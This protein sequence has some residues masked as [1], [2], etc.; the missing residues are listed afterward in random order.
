MT[1]AGGVPYEDPQKPDVRLG[2]VVVSIQTKDHSG[3]VQFEYGRQYRSE[4]LDGFKDT[5]HTRAPEGLL[6][7]CA[8][9]IISPF[10]RQH[11]DE[12]DG[13]H[14][15]VRELLERCPTDSYHWQRPI[16]AH[17]AIPSREDTSPKLHGGLIA[18]SS[19][20]VQDAGF[21]DAKVKQFQDRGDILAFEMEGY[22]V[23]SLTPCLHIRGICDYADKSKNQ[24]WQPYAAI[25]AAAFCKSVILGLPSVNTAS[26]NPEAASA[27]RHRF[28][29]F[30]FEQPQDTVSRR[31]TAPS[32]RECDE[33]SFLNSLPVYPTMERKLKG[34]KSLDEPIYTEEPDPFVR[35]EKT[36][37]STFYKKP[38]ESRHV[39]CPYC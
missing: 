8:K 7:R 24:E 16:T 39:R 28:D 30:T 36:T 1:R 5:G 34:K 35:R 38:P 13:F 37:F 6:Q 33:V 25:L 12:L 32:G 14:R 4:D 23:A 26:K 18:S 15:N 11:S 20:V 27:S 19:K 10:D 9:A 22:A 2:D 29:N 3:M 31:Q 17:V 21:R